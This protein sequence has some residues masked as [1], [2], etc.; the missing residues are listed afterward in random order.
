MLRNAVS[1]N[2]IDLDESNNNLKRYRTPVLGDINQLGIEDSSVELS[3][4]FHGT[5][6]LN[7]NIQAK[8]STV[9]N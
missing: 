3:S 7:F 5:G 1:I 4:S 8:K 9:N 2:I 6:N